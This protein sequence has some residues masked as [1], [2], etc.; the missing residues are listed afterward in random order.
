M[1][2]QYFEKILEPFRIL[3]GKWMGIKAVPQ[4]AVGDVKRIQGV[5]GGAV[6]SVKGGADK[7]K[8]VAGKVQ[9]AGQQAQGMAGQAQQAGAQAQQF[10]GQPP[11]MQAPQAPKAKKMGLFGRKKVCPQC[12]QP[13]EKGWDQCPYCLQAA[14]MAAMPGAHG[15]HGAPPPGPAG[16]Q[17]T[18]AFMAPS[19]GGGPGMQLLGWIVPIKGS[20][21]G[22]LFTLKPQTVIGTDPSQCDIVFTDGYMSS[23]HATIK[24]QAGVFILEDHSTNGTYVNDKRVKTHELVDNDFIKFGNTLAK[25][26]SL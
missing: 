3:K 19:A 8:G 26:K 23:R 24:A 17:K 2:W 22:E 12:G 21:R 9:G 4:R 25:F 13:Q 15:G 18:M 10:G 20:A 11:Q 14:Q 5:M 6:S 7:V 16:P 1:I